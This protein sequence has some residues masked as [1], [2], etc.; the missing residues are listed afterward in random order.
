MLILY[1]PVLRIQA[2]FYLM[3]WC[4]RDNQ[5]KNH[6]NGNSKSNSNPTTYTDACSVDLPGGTLVENENIAWVYSMP[7]K[8]KALYL[9][10]VELGHKPSTRRFCLKNMEQNSKLFY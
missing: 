7:L 2:P 10:G 5:S 9:S 1:Y 4:I 8:M 3:K 6:S